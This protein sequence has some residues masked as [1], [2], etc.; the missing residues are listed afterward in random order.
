VRTSFIRLSFY[1]WLF[2]FNTYI[3]SHDSRA[4]KTNLYKY[5]HSVITGDRL[6]GLESIPE[7]STNQKIQ[8]IENLLNEYYSQFIEDKRIYTEREKGIRFK[9]RT[10]SV[11]LE[12]KNNSGRFPVQ[13]DVNSIRNYYLSE[14]EKWA[15]TDKVRNSNI[16]FDLQVQLAKLYK[17]NSDKPKA[18]EAYKAAFRYRYLNPSEDVYLDENLLN[19]LTD[20]EKQKRLSYKESKQNLENKKKELSKIKDNFYKIHSEFAKKLISEDEANSNLNSLKQKE[21]SLKEEISKEEK[22][23]NTS[24]S[25][26][27]FLKTVNENDSI[28]LLSYA[29]LIKEMELENI[30]KDSIESKNK[31]FKEGVI[32]AFNKN[33]KLELIG[34]TQILEAGLKLNPENEEI[35]Y[36]LANEYKKNNKKNN[37]IDLFIRYTNLKDPN[38]ENLIRAYKNLGMLYSEIGKYVQASTYYKKY[39]KTQSKENPAST[40]N[41]FNYTI[42]SFFKEKLGDKETAFELFSTYLEQLSQSKTTDLSLKEKIKI[43]SSSFNSHFGIADYYQKTNYPDKELAFLNKSYSNL[44][45]FES[46]L[47]TQKEILDS[48]RKTTQTMKSNMLKTNTS[49]D[50]ISYKEEQEKLE[51]AR[52]DYNLTLNEYTVLKKVPLLLRIIHLEELNRNYRKVKELYSEIIQIGNEVEINSALRNLNRINKI[53]EDGY[54][55]KNLP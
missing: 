52:I 32:L 14:K 21:D 55:R 41:Y 38:P 42:G 53:I 18:L 47:S 23:F 27:Q 19:E 39:L 5:P 6:F 10:D 44:K 24:N 3:F 11:S 13:N 20:E 34:Y 45:E 46:I 15:D 29:K 4:D 8:A 25:Y 1:F 28:E 50:L 49:Q 7:Q 12:F 16:L 26:L 36:L 40:D 54:N 31:E 51:E 48:L 35:I 33:P 37:S 17:K 9:D 22:N 30:E 43:T 2:F